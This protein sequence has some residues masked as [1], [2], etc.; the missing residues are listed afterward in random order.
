MKSF[1]P[2]GMAT[3]GFYGYGAKTFGNP[4]GAK[5]G[6][7][8]A[9]FSLGNN[10]GAGPIIPPPPPTP[11]GP[12]TPTDTL[13]VVI[14]QDFNG[15]GNQSIGATLTDILT[16]TGQLADWLG[17]TFGKLNL[18][19]TL[20]LA[21]GFWLINGDS[22]GFTESGPGFAGL[23]IDVIPPQGF[24]PQITID[25]THLVVTAGGGSGGNESAA[26]S[27]GDAGDAIQIT[28]GGAGVDLVLNL[29]GGG[30]VWTAGG[31]GRWGNPVQGGS[32]GGGGAAFWSFGRG[33]DGGHNG[34]PFSAANGGTNSLATTHGGAGGGVFPA[35]GGTGGDVG[36][37]AHGGDNGQPL[38]FPNGQPG[39]AVRRVGTP[40][41]TTVTGG[42]GSIIGTV[43]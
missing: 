22:G 24:K 15:D 26:G 37:E 21:R 7:G 18:S 29:A 27:G 20:N 14:S 17:G 2:A 33:H 41:A 28:A 39:L 1:S 38:V 8:A 25:T 11:S 4:A 40:G 35:V 32:G 31:G 36:V 9:G 5:S 42:V 3:K 13:N 6:N 12:P 10:A 43:Q 30:A 16:A 34:A 19:A 23:V